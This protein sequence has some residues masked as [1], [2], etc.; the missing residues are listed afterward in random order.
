MAL[1]VFVELTDRTLKTLLVYDGDQFIGEY[2]RSKQNEV[3]RKQVEILNAESFLR[4]IYRD[5]GPFV[6]R[7]SNRER[8]KVVTAGGRRIATVPR[9]Y[10]ETP[11]WKK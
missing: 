1:R 8:T 11:S 5:H 6:V 10:W 3:A 9:E 4:K 7:W 2:E